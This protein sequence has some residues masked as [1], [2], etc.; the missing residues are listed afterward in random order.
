MREIGVDRGSGHQGIGQDTM[1]EFLG[2]ADCRLSILYRVCQLGSECACW[3]DCSC[4]LAAAQSL[5]VCSVSS[6]VLS[7]WLQVN[8]QLPGCMGRAQLILNHIIMCTAPFL[9]IAKRFLASLGLWCE[10]HLMRL[11]LYLQSSNHGQSELHSS[12]F[13]KPS[14]KAFIQ[15]DFI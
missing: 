12:L 9:K 10:Q 5:A 2:A 13:Y 11:K 4:S 7:L 3:S 1:V 14:S 8:T 6:C 15:S